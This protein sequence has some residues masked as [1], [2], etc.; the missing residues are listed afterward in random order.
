[1][2]KRKKPR[3]TGIHPPKPPKNP[4]LGDSDGDSRSSKLG[5]LRHPGVS[6]DSLTPA[7][8]TEP[9]RQEPRPAVSS[10]PEEETTAASFLGQLE[11][12]AAL[13][14]SSQT[15]LGRFVPQ[16][17]KPRKTVTRK[18]ETRE[19]DL[20]RRAVSLE[21]LPNPS[22]P[23][24][25]EGSPGPGD[26]MPSE[27]PHPEQSGQKPRTP[28]PGEGAGSSNSEVASQE[29]V[30]EQGTSALDGGNAGSSG[31]ERAQGP[32]SPE[33][34]LPCSGAEGTKPD[35]G[36]PQEGGAQHGTPEGGGGISSAP[37]P[38]PALA[39]PCM[40]AW[41]SAQDLP[42]PRQTPRGAGGQ[43]ES[44]PLGTTVTDSTDKVAP[45]T[46]QEALGVASPGTQ[47]DTQPSASPREQTPQGCMSLSEET[48]GGRGKAGPEDKPP[49][50][51]PGSPAA[52]QAVVP[53]NRG[54]AL[55][56]E[57]PGHPA[58]DLGPGVDQS[59]VPGPAVEWPGRAQLGDRQAVESGSQHFEG[60][61][62]GLSLALLALHPLEHRDATNGPFWEASAHQGSPKAPTPPPDPLQHPP[63]SASQAGWPESSA[64]E[65]DF[66]P[67]S[68][69]QDA[70]DAPDL[71]A[72][73]EQD[74]P[75]GNE[76]GLCW[77]G[78]SP[79]ASQGDRVLV[80][81]APPRMEDASDTVR[82]LIVELS[83][84]NRLIMSAHRDLEAF[85][86][87]GSRKARPSPC[88]AKGAG[89]M[90]WRDL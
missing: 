42:D 10:F 34:Q 62:V 8:P 72:P 49:S 89:A 44:C 2:S 70:L 36:A 38:A 80:A 68:Q 7:A 26:Q 77:P 21:A 12:E 1:M 31:P 74:G 6:E 33:G 57:D 67:D 32:G 55:D 51:T 15:S 19:E 46:E 90:S 85:K 18:A 79:G 64:M 40:K 88:L 59:Q 41:T 75:I 61:H 39:T 78:P 11:K 22:A 13:L 29:P 84:L 25:L 54:P 17:A 63:D 37:V 87:L 20:E 58:P 69:L 24:L 56:A 28:V 16:F 30:S 83:N 65:L 35:Q 82:G 5:G 60:G 73:P 52:F 50:D 27:S 53:G 4:R 86:R 43:A 76:S 48:T 14:P 81:E 71:E 47:A 45:E 9:S 23:G 3:T 66:L